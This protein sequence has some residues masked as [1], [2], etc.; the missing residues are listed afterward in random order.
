MTHNYQIEGMSCGSCEITVTKL[1]S[2]VKGVQNVSVDRENKSA[3]IKMSEHVPLTVLKEALGSASKFSI[4]EK[5]EPVLENES[6]QLRYQQ[7]HHRHKNQREE[8]SKDQTKYRRPRQWSPERNVVTTEIDV[9]VEL[10]EH[11]HEVNV[12]T[13]RQR[14]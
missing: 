5:A 9:R 14:Y 6:L 10:C 13:Y 4:S 8:C 3:S 7:V 2:A 1:L 12:Q 11:C